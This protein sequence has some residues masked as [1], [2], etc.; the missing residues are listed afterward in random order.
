[1]KPT[2]FSRFAMLALC[3]LILPATSLHAQTVTS[4]AMTGV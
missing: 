2:F 4:G 1:M 3:A